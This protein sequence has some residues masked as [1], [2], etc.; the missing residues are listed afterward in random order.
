M[1]HAFRR[2]LLTALRSLSQARA[3][4][5]VCVLSLGIG[6]TPV[7]AV[8]FAARI[9]AMPPAGLDVATIVEV[10]GIGT[11]TRAD[12]EGWSYPDFLRLRE[13]ET[14]V[15]MIGWAMA[16]VTVQTK[17]IARAMTRALFVTLNFFAD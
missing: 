11:K 8:P 6:M 16:P 13:A 7:L 10:E 1:L 17:G 9:P 14:G 15:A 4:T 2:D 5:V 12:R 3:F